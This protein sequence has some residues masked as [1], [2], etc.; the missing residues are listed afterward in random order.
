M[1]A[2]TDMR[3]P[4]DML[5]EALPL[6]GRWPEPRVLWQDEVFFLPDRSRLDVRAL[7]PGDAAELLEALVESALGWHAAAARD[8]RLT[9]SSGLRRALAAVGVP[10]VEDLDPLVWLESTALVRTLRARAAQ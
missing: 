6:D 7:D 3:M 5:D 2:L 4:P 1:V 10:L 9:T 8:E